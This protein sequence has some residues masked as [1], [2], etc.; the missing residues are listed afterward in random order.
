VTR[1]EREQAAGHTTGIWSP[2]TSFV[3]RA[4]DATELTR[5]LR[6]YRLVTVTGPGGVGKTRLATEV[7]RHVE[8]QFPDGVWFIELGAVSDAAQVPTEVMSAL[9]V[10]QDPGRPPLDVLAE[11]LAPRR[12]LLIMD[13]CEHVLAAVADLCVVVL[14]SADEVRVLATSREQLGVGGETRYRLRPLELPDSEE[15]RA[16]AQSAAAALFTERA[17]QADPRFSLDAESAPLVARV[18]TRLDGIPLAIELAAARVEALGMA[19]LADRIDDA[20]RLLAG[21]DRL[22]E[23]RHWSLT[24]VADWS[25]RLLTEPEQRVFRRLAAFP[26]PFTL[27]AAEAV[28]GPEAGPTVLRLVDCSLLVPPRPGV[29]GRARYAML[30]TLRAYGL[31]RLGG[32]Y[33]E[34]EVMSAMATFAW[35]LAGQAA[36]GLEAGE[37]RELDAL[38][39]L[40]AEDA[41]LSRALRWALDHDPDC[42]LRMAAAL[43]PWLRRRGRL[44]EARD[45]LRTA[46]A[47]SSPA[48]QAWAKAQLWLGHVLSSTTDLVGAVDAYEAVVEAHDGRGPSHE[49]VVALVGRCVVRLNLGDNPATVQDARRALA[50][51]RELGD[52]AAELQALAGLSLTAYYAGDRAKVLDWAAQAQ[53]LLRSDTPVDEGRW[54]RY[55]L[56][57]VLTE[58]GEL[59]SARRVCAAGLTLSRQADDLVNLASLLAY[60]A[61]LERL[62]GN[63][64]EAKAHLYEAATIALRAGDHVNLTNLI[65]E[66]GFLCAETGRWADAATLWAAHAADRK[67]RGLPS[68]QVDGDRGRPH[69]MR[70][71]EQALEPGQLHEA[72]ERGATMTVSAA[73]E[74]TLM[75]ASAAH[76]D[77]P[78]PAPGK[79][80]SPRERELVTLVAQ[81]HT[82]AEIAAR[83]YIS[84]RTVSSHLDRIRDKTGY[85]RRADLTRLALEES[86]V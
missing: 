46:V 39:W 38:R 13:N 5:L 55:I 57:T 9:G 32:A 45:L 63:I 67:R 10:Q 79:L 64:A 81:G 36:A 17:R 14:S 6:D 78:E 15:L 75:V 60:M 30:Q 33:E 52:S 41:T 69:Y 1:A 50:L 70:R 37:D 28:A 40:D 27:E 35:P 19:G 49:L 29:D 47:R 84:V 20:L 34:R 44:A 25:Y 8:D 83:L 56:A 18:V 22:A 62:A 61:I 26:G 71:I 86:L 24:A 11:T 12:L 54:C 31:A 43:A 3:G 85:R 66:C 21:A 68:E 65:E 58:T 77:S 80:L 51:A 2:L 59:D 4:H 7:A 72:E 16:V 82:N 73:A 23:A 74:F 42:A 76:E 53:E 48:N